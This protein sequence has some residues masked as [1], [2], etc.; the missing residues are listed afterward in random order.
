MKKSIDQLQAEL[1]ALSK[2]GTQQAKKENQ[3]TQDFMDDIVWWTWRYGP[4]HGA[5]DFDAWARTE[6]KRL[7]RLHDERLQQNIEEFANDDSESAKFLRWYWDRTFSWSFSPSGV[8][9]ILRE[10]GITNGLM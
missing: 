5:G 1:N 8:Q 6:G 4:N 2:K 10:D 9:H 3:P 7:T